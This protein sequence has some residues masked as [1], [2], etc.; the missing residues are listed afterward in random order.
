[1]NKDST[2]YGPT[3]VSSATN[4]GAIGCVA[5]VSFYVNITAQPQD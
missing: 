2:H 4:Y 3:L 5:D 1:M